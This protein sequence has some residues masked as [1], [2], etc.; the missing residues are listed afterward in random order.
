[1]EGWRT[2]KLVTWNV[3]GLRAVLEKG[4]GAFVAR[5]APDIICLQEVK[6]MQEQA[7]LRELVAAGYHVVFYSAEKKGYSGTAILTKVEPLTISKGMGLAEHDNEGRIITLEFAGVHVV[8]CYTPNSQRELVRLPY[9]Q[10]W[11]EAFRNYLLSLQAKKPVLWCGDLNVAHK[12]IDLANPKSNRMNAGFTDQE[13]DGFSK[14]LEAGFLDV[15]REF[16]PSPHRYTWWTFRM[17][18]REKNIG[19]RLD[20]WGASA[21]LREHLVNCWI[22]PDVMGSDHCPVVLETGPGLLF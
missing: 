12:E 7:D 1:M 22:L 21:S 5:E 10:T 11:D 13:R 8:T 6:A 9:R 20:Y 15:F 19:W 3:N 16:D 17:N 18:A 14:L 4:F 2:M